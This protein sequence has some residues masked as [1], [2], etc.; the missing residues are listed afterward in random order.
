MEN[1]WGIELKPGIRVTAA[2]DHETVT[3]EVTDVSETPE[4]WRVTIDGKHVAEPDL[5]L[6]LHGEG[7]G[8]VVRNYGGKRPWVVCYS[9]THP[10]PNLAGGIALGQ[11]SYKGH[12]VHRRFLTAEAAVKATRKEFGA[13]AIVTVAE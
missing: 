2:I 8:Y 7:E 4:G 3:G 1:R 10:S 13:D 5:V 6:M 9:P 11:A 12:T